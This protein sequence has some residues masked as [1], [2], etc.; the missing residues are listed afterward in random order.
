MQRDIIDTHVTCSAKSYT[1]AD[2][3]EDIRRYSIAGKILHAR[4]LGVISLIRT[5]LLGS[6]YVPA[7]Q[8]ILIRHFQ[9]I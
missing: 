4:Y 9:A 5:S 3:K 6:Q 7:N 8:T 1:V 2:Y